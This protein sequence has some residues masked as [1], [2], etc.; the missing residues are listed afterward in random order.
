MSHLSKLAKALIKLSLKK[1]AQ[2]VYHLENDPVAEERLSNYSAQTT[3]P[4]TWLTKIFNNDLRFISGPGPELISDSEGLG[5]TDRTPLDYFIDDNWEWISDMVIDHGVSSPE[6]LNYIGGGSF[7]S[8]WQM[9]DG[10]L[11]KITSPNAVGKNQSGI[12]EEKILLQ[13]SGSTAS[14]GMVRILAK[15][16]IYA[17]WGSDPDFPEETFIAIIMSKVD[18]VG[19]DSS[20]SKIYGTIEFLLKGAIDKYV[21]DYFKDPAYDVGPDTIISEKAMIEGIPWNEST[22]ADFEDGLY[23]KL[24]KASRPGTP[25][26]LVVKKINKDDFKLRD[27]WW[28]RHLRFIAQHISRDQ[29]DLHSGNIGVDNKGDLVFFDS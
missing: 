27:D 11:L 4:L 14:S 6:S 22:R 10:E 20:F 24:K 25:L 9:P 5:G 7:G 21:Q 28:D 17:R 3:L 16:P 15:Y 12:I 29:T 13:H 26:D 19:S 18:P 8:V 1:E 2:K 23:N